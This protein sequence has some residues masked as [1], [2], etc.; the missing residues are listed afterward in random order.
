MENF[1]EKCGCKLIDGD[2]YS[3]DKE[4][5]KRKTYKICPTGICGHTGISHR[6]APE[7]ER[8]GISR[9]FPILM[10]YTI[11]EKCKEK[12]YFGD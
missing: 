6:W 3:F 7:K 9:I 4:T 1:C 5:G 2:V 11:C 10:G 8:R 12:F